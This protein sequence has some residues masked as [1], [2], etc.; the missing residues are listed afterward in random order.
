M[1]TLFTTPKLFESHAAVIQRN[2]IRSWTLLRPA[3]EVILFG[4]DEGTAEVA[5]ELGVRHVPQVARNEHGT[6]LVGDLFAKAQR[7]ATGSLLC[8]VNADIMLM[9]DF[10]LA[11]RR[12]ARLKARFLMVGQG[13]LPPHEP[14]THINVVLNWFEEL[15]RRVP[16]N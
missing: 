5:S 6:P 14:V 7:L 4:D 1:L 16:T 15:T 11:A 13:E 2:A 10:V 9:N 3:C 8:Y 12:V